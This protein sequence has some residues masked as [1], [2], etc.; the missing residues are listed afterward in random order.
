VRL[1]EG[2][3]ARAELH[4]PHS[5]VAG[6]QSLHIVGEK[7]YSQRIASGVP[8]STFINPYGVDSLV[9]ETWHLGT[10]N[11]PSAHST[12][13]SP[14]VTVVAVELKQR[15]KQFLEKTADFTA[16]HLEDPSTDGRIH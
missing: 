12:S 13:A 15:S 5:I 11:P 1:P 16:I 9:Q 7:R 6:K 2:E 4:G 14:L 8:T 3:R 10:P